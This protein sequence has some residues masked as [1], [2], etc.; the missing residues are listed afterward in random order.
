MD[1]ESLYKIVFSIK[2]KN[3]HG[4]SVEKEILDLQGQTKISLHELKML[5]E[6]EEVD[7][8]VD[9][10]QIYELNY[11]GKAKEEL[12]K[13]INNILEG[14]DSGAQ[15]DEWIRILEENVK[16]PECVIDILEE[17]ESD[18]AEDILKKIL[19]YKPNIIHL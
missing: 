1:K 5:L 18:N 8:I 4:Q 15:M 16:Y 2:E 12:I 3:D 13:V 14:S 9:R 6:S 19:E 7:Y 11:K 10:I 17:E